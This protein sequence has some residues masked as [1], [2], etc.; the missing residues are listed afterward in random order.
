MPSTDVA[1]SSRTARRRGGVI[2]TLT[3]D[4][5]QEWIEEWAAFHGAQGFRVVIYDHH[6]RQ[7]ITVSSGR[8]EVVS[9]F[10]EAAAAHWGCGK[11][12]APS[13]CPLLGAC[14]AWMA[15]NS[16]RKFGQAGCHNAAYEDCLRRHGKS[17]RW[18]GNWD[19]DEFVF[20]CPHSGP[21]SSAFSAL[22]VAAAH[23]SAHASFN[24]QCLT[25]GPKAAAGRGRLR[26]LLWRAPD[27]VLFNE[28]TP[29]CTAKESYLCTGALEKR[30][31]S[32]EAL[33]GVRLHH[34][35][36]RPGS[37]PPMT[38][39][40]TRR[41]GICCHHYRF[42]SLEHVR[43]KEA[44]NHDPVITSQLRSGVF[45]PGSWYEAVYDDR[46]LGWLD[47]STQQGR[48]AGGKARGGRARA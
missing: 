42:A 31:S 46:M 47:Q 2:C 27:K 25:F 1:R 13:I 5:P 38:R 19:V 37:P 8:A 21:A 40:R 10:P 41:A 22:D 28:T 14:A 3:R 35:S 6:S 9:P 24:L 39:Q 34:H 17:A 4:E 23:E 33:T 44:L 12:A 43:R 32:A 30:L 29:R 18:I 48:G 11:A 7:P 16:T 20:P 36:L 26:T 45:A 15:S